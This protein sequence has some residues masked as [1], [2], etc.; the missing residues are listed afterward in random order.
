VSR[1]HI[2]ETFNTHVTVM[3]ALNLRAGCGSG[4]DDNLANEVSN[5]EFGN[6][7]DAGGCISNGVHA[8]HP[9]A[10]DD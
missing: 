5:G 2:P 1:L 3:A 7:S 4:R 6:N 10:Y 8:S 9:R